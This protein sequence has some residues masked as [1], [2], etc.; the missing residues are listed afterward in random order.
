MLIVMKE[1]HT[2]RRKIII[3]ISSWGEGPSWLSLIINTLQSPTGVSVFLPST[4]SEGW[5]DFSQRKS[6]NR[7]RSHQKTQQLWTIP[8]TPLYARDPVMLAYLMGL[9][10]DSFIYSR[11]CM[12][13]T[14]ILSRYDNKLV[15]NPERVSVFLPIYLLQ[16]SAWLSHVE[17]L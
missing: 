1:G 14:T 12:G 17:N 8:I 5:L 15:I 6:C 2:G 13:E 11:Q 4:P 7:S 10:E 3:S 9:G 16:K